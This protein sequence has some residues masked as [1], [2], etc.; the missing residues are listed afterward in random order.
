M[1]GAPW[2]FPTS[3]LFS[4]DRLERSP[5]PA[6]KRIPQPR[7]RVNLRSSRALALVP[8]FDVGTH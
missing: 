8:T 2:S 5:S 4:E 6:A 3:G 7:M 1:K